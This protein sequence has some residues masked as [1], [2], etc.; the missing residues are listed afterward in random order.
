MK[1]LDAV[2]GTEEG[3]LAEPAA[4]I[5]V[6]GTTARGVEYEIRYCI[7]P[8]HV[9]PA[10]ARNTIV[11]S[12]LDHLRREG[13]SLSYPAQRVYHEQIPPGNPEGREIE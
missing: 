12:V 9:S 8:R 5:R 10:K 11:R 4:K 3:P 1:A 2:S 6:N 7:I 13:L